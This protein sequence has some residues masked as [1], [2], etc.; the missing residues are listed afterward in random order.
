MIFIPCWLR[1]FSTCTRSARR[2]SCLGI[3]ES[4]LL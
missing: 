4:R 3:P 1:P 2:R